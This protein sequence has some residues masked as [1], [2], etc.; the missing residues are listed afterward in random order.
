MK[1]LL[2]FIVIILTI[3][4][5]EEKKPTTKTTKHGGYIQEEIGVMVTQTELKEF[6]YKGHTYISCDVRDGKSIT[7]AGHCLCNPN[8]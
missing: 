7:H 3:T 4:A 8:F 2:L 6:E 5:C 1:K